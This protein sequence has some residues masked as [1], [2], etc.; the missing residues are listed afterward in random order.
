MEKY[1]VLANEKITT[2]TKNIINEYL[3]S[4]KLSN[5][6]EVTIGSRLRYLERVF[7][8]IKKP[9]S[10]ITSDDMLDYIRKNHS[11]VKESTLLWYI[12]ILSR[13]QN[14]CLEEGYIDKVVV[15]N[16]W[17]PRPP[18]PIPKYLDGSELA[19]VKLEAEKLPLRDRT[20]F[21]FLLSSGSRVGEVY[22]LNVDDVD[23]KNRTATVLGKGSKI[24]QVHFSSSCAILLEEYIKARPNTIDALFINSNR[25]RLSILSIRTM[26]NR[27]GEKANLERRLT[28]HMLRHTFSTILL[29]KGSTLDFIAEEL[30]HVDTNTTRIY[31][32]LLQE[33]M[34]SLYRRFMG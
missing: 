1:W 32:R 21:E 29:S 9:L 10:E 14:F 34:V 15:K 4:L 2:Q 26:I 17:K 33:Q 23:I 11:N 18:L 27:L 20:I 5:R 8:D 19:K 7:S 3:L 30:G 24:R 22:R 12:N 28:P 16:R 31:A 6:S 25:K 13:F